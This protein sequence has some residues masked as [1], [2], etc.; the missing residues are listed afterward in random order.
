MTKIFCK[1]K[2]KLSRVGEECGKPHNSYLH[3]EKPPKKEKPS[4]SSKQTTSQA[5]QGGGQEEDS[6]Q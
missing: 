2:M 1:E 5:E 6:T 3:W 4:N